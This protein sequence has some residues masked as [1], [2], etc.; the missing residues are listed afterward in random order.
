MLCAIWYHLYNLKNV[1]NTHEGMLLFVKWQ[2][3]VFEILQMIP[4]YVVHVRYK[5]WTLVGHV[6]IE[7]SHSSSLE[8]NIWE[9]VIRYHIVWKYISAHN[10]DP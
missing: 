9:Y 3:H 1:K 7:T 5:K 10:Q 2:A 6:I 4:N 8:V